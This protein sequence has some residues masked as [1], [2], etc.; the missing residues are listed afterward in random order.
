MNWLADQFNWFEILSAIGRINTW[1][2]NLDLITIRDFLNFILKDF[3]ILVNVTQP[4]VALW[5]PAYTPEQMWSSSVST[6][7][8]FVSVIT[9]AHMFNANAFLYRWIETAPQT[10]VRSII[11]TKSGRI[12]EESAL[13]IWWNILLRDVWKT[14]HALFHIVKFSLRKM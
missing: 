5:G 7:F 1:P 11:E 4:E 2:T 13:P 12:S 14:M 3:I 8:C 6:L 10:C 9:D